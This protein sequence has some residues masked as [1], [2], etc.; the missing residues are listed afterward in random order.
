MIFGGL[1]IT[2]LLELCILGQFFHLPPVCMQITG[3]KNACGDIFQRADT[4]TCFNTMLVLSGILCGFC[5]ECVDEV[6]VF[7]GC[8]LP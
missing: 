3:A 7:R 4:A 5:G 1:A 6:S 8:V 2:A